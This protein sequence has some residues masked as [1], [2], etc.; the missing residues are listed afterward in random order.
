MPADGPLSPR[1]FNQRDAPRLQEVA[2]TRSAR[3][4]RRWRTAC[5]ASGWSSP[6]PTR[7]WRRRSSREG[8][9]EFLE[10][11]ARAVRTTWRASARRDRHLRRPDVHRRRW[12]RARCFMIN[13]QITAADLMAY[14]LYVTTLLTSIRT[15]RGVYRAVPARHDGHRALLRGHGR[16][17]W[18]STTRP[19]P[20][21]FGRC[22]GDIAFEHVGFPLR[23]RRPQRALRTSTC[24][25]SPGRQRGPG[26]ALGRR[27]NHAVQPDSPLLRRD[28]R[29][30]PHRRARISADITLKS[31]REQHRR[32]AAGGVPLLRHRV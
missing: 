26:R 2:A 13:G 27:Q 22:A 15:D 3:S 20:R 1:Y 5:S 29:A 21:T 18:T 30:H 31:L 6:S 8:N 10:H 24:T 9:E 12:W 7:R 4:T 23:G 14:L 32:G 16:A 11:Q 28:R 19:A 17:R 25:C